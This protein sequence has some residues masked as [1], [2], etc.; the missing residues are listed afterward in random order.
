MS[1]PQYQVEN[2]TWNQAA[3]LINLSNSA[4]IQNNTQAISKGQDNN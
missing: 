4:A 2:L 3:N 1:Q